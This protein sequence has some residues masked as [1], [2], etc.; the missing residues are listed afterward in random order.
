MRGKMMAL[1]CAQELRLAKKFNDGDSL[2][3]RS[4]MSRFNAA[5]NNAALDDASRL[6]ELFHW[7]E[8]S[9]AAMIDSFASL[10][11]AEEAYARARQELNKVFVGRQATQWFR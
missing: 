5:V 2:A 11:D 8:G 6:F 3:F 1:Q 10:P 7:F 4:L 9:A